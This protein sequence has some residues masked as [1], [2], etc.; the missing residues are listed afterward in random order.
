VTFASMVPESQRSTVPWEI[1]DCRLAL[2][3]DDVAA[4]LAAHDIVRVVHF[5]MYR[6]PPTTW[7]A[8]KTGTRHWG[9]LAVDAAVF[10]KHD[11]QKLDVLHDFHGR[12]GATTCGP[13]TGPRPAGPEAL[14]LRQIVCDAVDAKIFNVALTPDYN[15]PH[16]NHFHLELSAKRGFFVH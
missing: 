5:S 11:G 9:A 13:G 8:E 15:W 3:L 14:E 10:I 12:I 4:Q 7:P 6:P 16:R 2:A 1:V